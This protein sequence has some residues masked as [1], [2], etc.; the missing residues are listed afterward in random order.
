MGY[1]TK[2]YRV[3]F[4]LYISQTFSIFPQ[5]NQPRKKSSLFKLK[6]Q[7]HSMHHRNQSLQNLYHQIMKWE[8]FRSIQHKNSCHYRYAHSHSTVFLSFCQ[9]FC[10]ACSSPSQTHKNI[11]FFIRVNHQVRANGQISICHDLLM[12]RASTLQR[13]I[14]IFRPPFEAF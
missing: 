3:Y 10:S 8:F 6:V 2:M 13:I 9:R 11:S 5:K 4:K 14:L 12:I 7:L 1:R